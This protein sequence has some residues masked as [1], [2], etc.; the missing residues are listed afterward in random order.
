MTTTEIIAQII[1]IFAMIFNL[2]SYQ[3][4]TRNK[5]IIFQLFGTTLFTVNFL[6]LGAMVGGLLNLVGAI[7]AIIFIN[8]EKLR[9]DHIAW[10]IGFVIVYFASYI[11]TFTLF[12]K[13]PTAFN[14]IIEFLPLIGMIAT[15]ISYRF[16]D[17]KAIRRFGLI[18]SPAWLIYNIANLA[19]GAILCEVLS[20]CSIIIGIVRLD[21]K[22][23][24]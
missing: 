23:K 5:A 7:R 4:K 3:Q 22:K 18:S 20:L 14:F 12:G 21:R 13:E 11:L 8:K 6:M 1:G 9:A 15:T 10:Q 2:L 19:V 17:A 24:Q 16:T